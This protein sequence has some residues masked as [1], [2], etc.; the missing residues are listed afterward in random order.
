MIETN[1]ADKKETKKL[2]I[3]S[4]VRVI[5]N[6]DSNECS[7]TQKNSNYKVN[8][9][10]STMEWNKFRFEKTCAWHRRPASIEESKETICFGFRFI[11]SLCLVVDI[12][13]SYKIQQVQSVE[14]IFQFRNQ[15]TTAIAALTLR[16]HPLSVLFA[17]EL[18][19]VQ[20]TRNEK[21]S[22]HLWINN[23]ELS[24]RCIWPMMVFGCGE[25]WA[26]HL[27]K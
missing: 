14:C 16:L 8:A 22:R 11:V 19:S 25:C 6:K 17:L 13:F 4:T 7:S 10:Q 27:D 3:V 12:S 18:P 23:I 1:A 5:A 15:R 26:Q 9:I 2:Q 20:R 21:T 24:W